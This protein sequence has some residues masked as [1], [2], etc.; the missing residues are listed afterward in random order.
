[1]GFMKA[2][3]FVKTKRSIIFPNSG[4]CKQLAEW[5]KICKTLAPPPPINENAKLELSSS[6]AN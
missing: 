1:V 6:N 2:K 3:R 4:F 5:E